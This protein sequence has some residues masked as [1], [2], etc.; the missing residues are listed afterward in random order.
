MKLTNKQFKE[1]LAEVT[2]EELEKPEKWHYLSFAD[3]YFK[4][5]VV[6]KGHG[7]TDCVSKAHR[8]GINPGGQ[9]MCVAFP[10]SM[11]LPDEKY[12]NRLLTREDVKAIW[13]DAASLGE[14]EERDRRDNVKPS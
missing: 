1:R 8:L 5:A 2:R 3:G 14:H 11:E 4:G 6:I 7:V 10:D 13:P 9:V 12:R